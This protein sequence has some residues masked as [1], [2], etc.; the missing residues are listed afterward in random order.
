MLIYSYSLVVLHALTP[1][2][3]GGIPF[4]STCPAPT[5]ALLNHMALH[6]NVKCETAQPIV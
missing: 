2:R 4:K 3:F 6:I 5:A 1:P